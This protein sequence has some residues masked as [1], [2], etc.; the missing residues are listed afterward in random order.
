MT[1]RTGRRRPPGALENEVLAALWA[2][3]GPMT[4]AQV[5]DELGDDLAYTT[6]MTT[7]SR[8]YEKGLVSRTS[9]GRGYAYAPMVEEAQLA[10]SR[11]QAVLD[12][13]PD[14]AEVL[15]R[16]VGSLDSDDEKLLRGLL[17]RVRRR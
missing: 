7:L 4:P 16:F 10:A 6:V 2:H 3:D 11:M 13:G 17:K 14:R 9:A 8:L 12:A 1:E 15:T 5:R